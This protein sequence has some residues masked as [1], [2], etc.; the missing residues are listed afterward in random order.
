MKVEKFQINTYMR[1]GAFANSAR[2]ASVAPP[3]IGDRV[4]GE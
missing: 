3:P 1:F 4:N 2:G